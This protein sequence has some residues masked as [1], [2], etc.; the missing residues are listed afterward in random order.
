M[1]ASA[2][3]LATGDAAPAGDGEQGQQQEQEAQQQSPISPEV[4]EQLASV[5]DQ[6]AQMR[7]WMEESAQQ[8]QVAPAAEEQQPPDLSFVN[9]EDPA[10]DPQRAATELLSVLEKQTN[11]ALEAKVGPLQERLQAAESLREAELLTKEFPELDDEK[12]QDA[13]METTAKWVEAA[14]LPADTAGNMQVVRA[15]YMMGRAAEL[16]TQEQTGEAPA[17]ATLEGA[18]GASPGGT[19]GGLTAESIFG[20]QGRRSP[21]PF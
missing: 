21:L 16:A 8:Q 9:P 11:D 14:G 13:L 7:Q 12:A 1:E 6:L 3:G 15:V 17:A 10:Y 2:A 19:G 20:D 4:A 18:G 5:P